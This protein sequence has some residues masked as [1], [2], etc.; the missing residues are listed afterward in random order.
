VQGVRDI[1]IKEFSRGA[2]SFAVYVTPEDT[3]DLDLIIEDVQKAIDENRALGV[4]GI[5]V[6]PFLIPLCISVTLVPKSDALSISDATKSD[7]KREIIYYIEE[8]GIGEELVITELIQRIMDVSEEVKDIQFTD[9]T[10]NGR[11]ALMTN[12]SIYWDQKF[13]PD[14][15]TVA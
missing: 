14:V 1:Y 10:V 9:F 2:G 8:L 12:Q 3:A 6:A 15:I 11:P 4:K 7:V 5:A 13:S